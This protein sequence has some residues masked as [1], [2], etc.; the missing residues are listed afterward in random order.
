MTAS[1]STAASN[2][3]EPAAANSLPAIFVPATDDAA[4]ASPSTSRRRTGRLTVIAAAIAI[5]AALGSVAGALAGFALM[6]SGPDKLP[7]VTAQG[8]PITE[9][10]SQMSADIGALRS[11]LEASNKAAAAQL[12]KIAERVER[13]EKA[14]TDPA[15][16][17]AKL[18]EAVERLE[19]KVSGA[20]SPD[21]TG[22]IVTKSPA[23]APQVEGWVLRDIVGGR[24]FIESRHGIFEVVPGTPLP[25]GGR[26]ENIR[27][28]EGRWVVVTSRGLITARD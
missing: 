27:R 3:Q 11:A 8:K 12:T 10:L 2:G 24:A 25:G 16:R 18:S 17:L 9:T 15:G 21:V 13:A 14:Q 6:R 22:S 4:D 19:K 7:G 28:Q 5:A 1:D 20:A 23:R 26:V